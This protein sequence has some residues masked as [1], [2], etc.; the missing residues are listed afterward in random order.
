MTKSESVARRKGFRPRA[1]LIIWRSLAGELWRILGLSVFVLVAIAVFGAAIRPLASGQVGPVGAMQLMLLAALPMLQ[2]TLPFAA[3]FAATMTY[4]RLVSDNEALAASVGGLSYR[5]LLTPATLTAAILGLVIGLMTHSVI[6]RFFQA[7]DL[8][9]QKDAARLI[10]QAVERGESVEVQDLLVYADDV[11]RLPAAAVTGVDEA[12]LLKGVVAVNTDDQGDVSREIAAE[13]VEVWLQPGQVDQKSVTL[14]T[15][16]LRNWFGKQRGENLMRFD[17]RVLQ[18]QPIALPR[19]IPDRPKFLT[20][21][22][23]G[24]LRRNP[25]QYSDVARRRHDLAGAMVSHLA[26]RVVKGAFENEGRLRLADEDGGQL[27][28]RASDAMLEGD[29]WRLV[30][31]EGAE[32]IELDWTLTDGDFRRQTAAR[33]WLQIKADSRGRETLLTLELEDIVTPQ[34]DSAHRAELTRERLHLANDPAP[35]IYVMSSEDLLVDAERFIDTSDAEVAASIASLRDELVDRMT[36]LDR[37]ITGNLHERFALA[38]ACFVMTL[39]GGVMAL[40]LRDSLPLTVYTW[41][42]FPAL[43]AI[44]TI[45]G[46][47]NVVEDN[48]PLGLVVIWGGLGLLMAYTAVVYF[49]LRRH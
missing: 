48:V 37:R 20:T 44:V 42:F 21:S 32:R 35:D 27:I 45:S 49:S 8:L 10:V 46:G 17:Q 40:R 9:I 23:L 13:R 43:L 25:D 7:M 12:L 16:R 38:A 3:G 33:A 28:L 31:P 1:P 41:S 47:E 2:F 30:A 22:Q 5:T 34:A 4:H 11:A 19:A 18:T 36:L 15:M 29:R 39:T 14:V 24:E 6:P 26:G